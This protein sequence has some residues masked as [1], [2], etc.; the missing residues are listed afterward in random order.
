MSV[1]AHLMPSG[2]SYRA[3]VQRHDNSRLL[4]P[5]PFHGQAFAN[6]YLPILFKR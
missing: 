1:V 2:T 4:G 3:G 5:H 6:E